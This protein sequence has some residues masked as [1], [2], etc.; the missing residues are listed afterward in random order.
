MHYIFNTKGKKL[1][2]KDE[3]ISKLKGSE[4]GTP[5]SEPIKGK[6]LKYY[7]ILLKYTKSDIESW[8]DGEEKNDLLEIFS[9]LEVEEINKK[10]A[11]KI[12]KDFFSGIREILTP[13]V[14][15]DHLNILMS[16]GCSIMA[17][18]KGINDGI[19]EGLKESLESY[20][21]RH[22]TLKDKIHALNK[23]TPEKALDKLY[24]IKSYFENIIE[25]TKEVDKIQNV[26]SKFQEILLKSY[27]LGIDYSK[28]EIH[29]NFL[30]KLI[31][32]KNNTTSIFTLNYDILIEKASEEL[33]IQ[34][35]NGFQGFHFRKFNPANF[36]FKNHVETVND[37]RVLTKSINLIKLHG[38]LSW[39]YNKDEPLYNIIENQIKLNQNKINFEDIKNEAIIYPVQTKKSH[40][41]DLPYSEM[42]RQLNEALNKKNSTLFLMGYSFLDEHVNDLLNSALSNPYFNLVIFAYS[43]VDK[44]EQNKQSE[45]YKFYKR[46]KTDRRITIL[47]GDILG[48]FE[49][50]AND[51]FPVDPPKDIL[52]EL[53][54]VLKKGRK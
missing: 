3:K 25:D 51:L 22:T 41:L 53:E 32:T 27:V 38:S 44:I 37:E 17:G 23:V 28:T 6:I 42:F 52:K 19:D 50:I 48:D 18:S 1:N 12:I 36:N 20:N 4:E 11:E 47:M 35:N 46:A 13:L 16:N 2:L 29:R 49:Y 10:E 9:S 24:Q 43:S 26:I 45:L 14:N 31:G 40:S 39:Q 7:K 5:I 33:N 8:K 30:M 34:L 15:S 54:I 21:S